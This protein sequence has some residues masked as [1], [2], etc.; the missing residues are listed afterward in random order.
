MGYEKETKLL[1]GLCKQCGGRC[2]IEEDSIS[3]SKIEL[4]RLKQKYKFKNG[5]IITPYG[6][7]NTIKFQENKPCPFL[8]KTKGKDVKTGC[9]LD[10][11]TRPLSCRLYPLTFLFE[12]GKTKFYLSLFCPHAKDI[13]KFNAWIRESI[14]EAINDLN[15]WTEEEKL[16]RTYIHKKLHHN[17]KYIIEVKDEK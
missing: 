2:C 14:K 10:V 7:I 13:S 1:A 8:S 4:K 3:I 9:V 6:K 11:K 17:H 12:N 5:F 16:V 15:D